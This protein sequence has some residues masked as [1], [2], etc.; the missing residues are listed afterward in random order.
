MIPTNLDEGQDEGYIQITLVTVLGHRRTGHAYARTVAMRAR[1]RGLTVEHKHDGRA[2][3]RTHILTL[4]GPDESRKKFLKG[5]ESYRRAQQRGDTAASMRTRRQE[6]RDRVRQFHAEL[7]QK[8]PEADSGS[9]P[10]AD[11]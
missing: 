7:I 2:L 5:W 10:S 9:G 6:L 8:H 4:R 11:A 1:G 3:V